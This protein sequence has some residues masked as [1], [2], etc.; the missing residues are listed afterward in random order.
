MKLEQRSLPV[1]QFG[2][3]AGGGHC[4]PTAAVTDVTDVTGQG[5]LQAPAGEAQGIYE[6]RQVPG[7]T[8]QNC[9]AE[10]SFPWSKA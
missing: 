9:T 6:E 1:A 7:R 8:A 10:I 4:D 3:T 2:V 5:A